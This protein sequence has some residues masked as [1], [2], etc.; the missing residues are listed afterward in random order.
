[1]TNLL[2]AYPLFLGVETIDWNL[3]QFLQA[4]RN[5]K[6][7]G[8]TS[9]L[10]KIADGTNLWYTGIG[11][12]E[13]VLNT[14][15]VTGIKA[16]PYLYC[17]G[18][19]FGALDS[20][21]ALLAAA[22]KHS[23][24]VV[25]DMEQQFNGESG[26]GSAVAAALKP[27]AGQ[28]GVTTWADPELQS[29]LPVLEALKS[30]VNFWLPQVYSDF[31]ASD[32]HTRF[33]QFGL[34]YYPILNLGTDAGANDPVSIATSANSPVIGFWEYQAAISTWEPIVKEIIALHPK[35][36]V[37]TLSIP[38]G[39]HYDAATETLTPPDCKY[40][41]TGNFAKKILSM[42]VWD[43]NNKPLENA[44]HVNVG[45]LHT[46]PPE[47]AI[48]QIYAEDMYLDYAGRGVVR[49]A[50]GA[51]VAKCYNIIAQLEQQIKTLQTQIATLKAQ[52]ITPV[53]TAIG[54][55]IAPLQAM[56]ANMSLLEQEVVQALD[57]QKVTTQHVIDKLQGK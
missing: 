23:G 52:P 56:I 47:P 45:E 55:S 1:M 16:V 22:M 30:C 13:A 36:E 21:D 35:E 54:E 53:S 5:A 8:C 9:L 44:V 3:S 14:V 6:A 57:V 38:T 48:R 15:D 7:L 31:L 25:A 46:S 37:P 2:G 10:V 17:Y 41:V 51:E 32:Y 39:W 42:P 29:W 49:S 20:E 43:T 50:C 28:F 4:A 12:W 19:T 40:V 24:I 27:V 26:W 33:D 11:G 18:N 34:P